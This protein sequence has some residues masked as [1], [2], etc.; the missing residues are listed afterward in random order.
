MYVL[1]LFLKGFCFCIKYR[2]EL[3]QCLSAQGEKAAVYKLYFCLPPPC[4]LLLKKYLSLFVSLYNLLLLHK[5][6]LITVC[7]SVL[8]HQPCCCIASG[9]LRDLVYN[10]LV[11]NKGEIYCTADV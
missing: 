4:Q 3:L 5:V 9:I 7:A 11:V 6:C 10:V 1:L 2:H 8:C